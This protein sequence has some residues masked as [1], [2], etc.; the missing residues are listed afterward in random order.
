MSPFE[1]ATLTQD[2]VAYRFAPA[3][4]IASRPNSQTGSMDQARFSVIGEGPVANFS[5]PVCVLQAKA[6][7]SNFWLWTRASSDLISTHNCVGASSAERN[8]S[9]NRARKNFATG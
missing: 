6:G 3:P 2:I 9:T 1:N 5:R 8:S 4:P 7:Q